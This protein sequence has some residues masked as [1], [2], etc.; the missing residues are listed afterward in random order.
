M[1]TITVINIADKKE[2][3]IT[4]QRSGENLMVCPVCSYDRKKKNLKCFSYNRTKDVGSCNHCGITLVK[5]KDYTPIVKIEYKRPI[6]RNNTELSDKAIKWFESRK[7]SQKTLLDLKVTEGVEFMPQI[8]K[9]IN[10]VQFN[11]FRDGELV[12]VKYRD[13]NKNFKLVSGAELIFYNLDCLKEIDKEFKN[14]VVIVEGE[15]DALSLHEAGFKNVISVPN[16]ASTGKNNLAYLD[17]CVDLFGDD[18]EFYLAL[19]NDRAGNNLRDELALRLGLEKCYKISFK[20]CKDA[21]ECLVKHGIQG[22]IEAV[23]N[24][25]EYPIE[26]IF[27]AS[28]ISDEIDDYYENGLPKGVGIGLPEFDQFLRFHKGYMTVITGIPSHGKSEV[29]DFI[30]AKLNVVDGW[31]IAFYSPEN[32][33]LQLHF[34]KIA[35]KLIGK[36]FN[37]FGRMN[38][39]EVALA[40]TYFND[41]FYFIKP[42]KD[43][44]LDNILVKVRSLVRKKGI[45]AFV[46]DAWN[47]LDHQYSGNETQYVSAQ[48]D[49]LDNFCQLNNVHLFLVA[50]PTKIQKDKQTGKFEVPNLYSISGSAN[51]FNK[52]GNGISVYRNF[53]E[54]NKRSD[55]HI[56]K[57]KFKHWGEPGLVSWN[58]DKT[59]GRYYSAATDAENWIGVTSEQTRFEI[60]QNINALKVGIDKKDEIEMPF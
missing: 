15:I 9:E 35:E 26:G 50:H 19:D 22:I 51:F 43:V 5:K 36:P 47:K 23:S 16:G 33:P 59:T 48:L 40:K 3:E 56:Q 27:T 21:N 4:V 10:T 18:M 32:Q 29:L 44:S 24:K 11:Y 6:W 20:D 7:I 54:D 12:N 37:G 14:Y 60:P 49:K 28:D 58:W 55:I 53:G 39:N 34:S 46:I 31:K 17:N 45:S 57:V 42:E 30:C 25:K 13:G 41:N 38:V 8:S 2:Y 52:T 1:E